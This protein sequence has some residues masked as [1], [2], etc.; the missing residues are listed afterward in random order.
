MPRIEVKKVR[1]VGN[2]TFLVEYRVQSDGPFVVEAD[3]ADADGVFRVRRRRGMLEQEFALRVATHEG[4]VV[5]LPV[6]EFPV[7][8]W[9]A[10]KIEK[11]SPDPPQELIDEA[12]VRIRDAKTSEK[13]KSQDLLML[14]RW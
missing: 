4:V 6:S 7:A 2:D 5:E 14:S 3:R 8:A 9:K 1:D 11:E 13:Q 10:G 12:V